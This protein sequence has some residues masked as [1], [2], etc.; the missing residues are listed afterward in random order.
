MGRESFKSREPRLFPQRSQVG[1]PIESLG[2]VKGVARVPADESS[3]DSQPPPPILYDLVAVIVWGLVVFA[4]I[5]Y[6][7]GILGEARIGRGGLGCL[8]LRLGNRWMEILHEREG[9]PGPRASRDAISAPDWQR[10]VMRG[11]VRCNSRT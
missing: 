5:I 7:T 10:R 4:W 9:Y 3:V 6:L 2:Y 11:P 8:D 1:T